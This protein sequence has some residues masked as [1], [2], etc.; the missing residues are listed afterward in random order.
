[1][2]RV[3]VVIKISMRPTGERIHKIAR[4]GEERRKESKGPEKRRR[5]YH[6]HGV[7]HTR[8]LGATL[9]DAREGREHNSESSVRRCVD[10]TE[11][12]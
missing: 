7:R 3:V 12:G 5:M 6:E 10:K 9:R 11:S 4:R 1:M 2:R 8:W